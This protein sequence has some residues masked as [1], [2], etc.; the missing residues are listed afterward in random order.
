MPWWLCFH[1]ITVFIIIVAG[2]DAIFLT[3]FTGYLLN[4]E[5]TRQTNAAVG[6]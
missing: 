4:Q 5:I 3:G 1:C 2:I 6:S